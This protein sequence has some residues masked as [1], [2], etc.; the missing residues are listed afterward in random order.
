MATLLLVLMVYA[1]VFPMIP[2]V[3][4]APFYEAIGARIDEDAKQPIVERP[5][6]AEVKLAIDQEW[7]KLVVLALLSVLVFVLQ[8]APVIGQVL[9]L[10]IGFA[11]LILTLGA[12][13]VGPALARRGLMLGDRRRWV[14]KHWRPVV[15]IGLAKALGLFVPV[16]NIVVLPMAAAGGTLLV[17]IYDT[18]N[19]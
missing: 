10:I 12:D 4:G 5:W 18:T 19:V 16:L 3:D 1:F 7:R 15:G 2:V 9:S 17:Q 6:Y 13:S 8:F 11:V 14:L